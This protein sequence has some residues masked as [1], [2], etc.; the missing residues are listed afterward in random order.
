MPKLEVPPQSPIKMSLGSASEKK[1]ITGLTNIGNTCYGNAVLQA[2]RSQVD[3]T[4]FILQGQHTE[5][6]KRKPASEKSKLL[7]SYGELVRSLWSS[8]VGT[9][10]TKEFWGAMI[11]AAI[12]AGYEQFRI[13]MA[14]DAHE[15]LNFLLDQF[16]E[17]LSEEVVMTLRSNPANSDIKG[18]LE[19]W[20]S[21][22]E[23]SYSPLV[24]LVF[25][26]QRKCVK[27][28][29]CSAE[30]ITWET[31]NMTKVSVKKSDTP[32]DLLDLLVSEGDDDAIEDYACDTCKPKRT[33]ATV[34]RSLWRLGNWVIIML[35]RNENNG[36]RINTKVN[37]PLECSFTPAFSPKSQEPS[38]RD[39]YEL[40]ASI[41]HHGAA[42]GGHYTAQAKHPVTGKWVHYD[43]ESARELESGQLMLDPSTYIVMYRRIVPSST[44]ESS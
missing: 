34:T 31:L 16:H 26:I 32:V 42:G 24:E 40:F 14:H 36:R 7:E 13:P 44:S 11:P 6:L 39:S 27:C 10:Q 8:E 21:S 19:F 35:K 9:V 25:S 23:K 1:G 12:K 20:K 28:E 33:K 2:L 37:I 38:S 15:F 29:G 22:F 17:A 43:D 3:F 4:I 18:A 5:L 41:H 30:S